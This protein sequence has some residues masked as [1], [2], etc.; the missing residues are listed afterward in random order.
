MP[1]ERKNLRKGSSLL[2][3]HELIMA[4][5]TERRIRQENIVN[6]TRKSSFNRNFSKITYDF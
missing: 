6:P 3:T 5:R 1:K 2:R 4:S